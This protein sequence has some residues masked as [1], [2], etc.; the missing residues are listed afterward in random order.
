ML[1]LWVMANTVNAQDSGTAT[2]Y[3]AGDPIGW[4]SGIFEAASHDA[5][6]AEA[7]RRFA[8]ENLTY[9]DVTFRVL[10]EQP[11]FN[12]GVPSLLVPAGVVV[13]AANV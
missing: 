9:A 4:N 11:G 7:A 8:A 5:A 13:L 2:R 3:I 10:P 12:H 1:Y 6:M